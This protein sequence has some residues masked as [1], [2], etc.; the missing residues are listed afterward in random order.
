MTEITVTVITKATI[1]AITAKVTSRFKNSNL[2][3]I[4]FGIQ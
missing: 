2:K 4:V 1:D 3:R